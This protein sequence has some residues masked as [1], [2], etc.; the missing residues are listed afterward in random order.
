MHIIVTTVAF[1]GAMR[2]ALQTYACTRVR[3]CSVYICHGGH[4]HQVC[5]ACCQDVSTLGAHTKQA[6]S[7]DARLIS[8]ESNAANF[9]EG[10]AQHF[11][12]HP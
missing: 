4:R 10:S 7:T 11:N 12:R 8:F 9:L 3:S 5:S 6:F 2:A 1:Y